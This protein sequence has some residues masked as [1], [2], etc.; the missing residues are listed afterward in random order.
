[1]ATAASPS[2]FEL[3]HLISLELGGAPSD[4]RNLWPESHGNSYNKDGLENS[5]QAQVCAHSISLAKAQWRIVHWPR[6]SE[7]RRV[8]RRRGWWRGRLG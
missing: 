1:M 6:S 8:G 5:L 2:G 7:G 3:D 4:E